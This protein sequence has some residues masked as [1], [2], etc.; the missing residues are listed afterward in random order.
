MEKIKINYKTY[1]ELYAMLKGS[2]EDFEMACINIVNLKLSDAMIVLLAKKL[3]YGR[4]SS[5]IEKF[6]KEISN[7]LNWEIT[8]VT[9]LPNLAWENVYECLT[10][11]HITKLEKDI[12]KKELESMVFETLEG[13][14]Y[15]FIKSIKLELK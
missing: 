15:K 1:T 12:I 11:A 2:D 10:K 3:S 13:L 7:I 5:F 6:T 14:D 8:G 9:G 4:R